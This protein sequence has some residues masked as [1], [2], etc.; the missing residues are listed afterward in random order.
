VIA[1][2]QGGFLITKIKHVSE[3]VFDRLLK[4]HDVEISPAQ[5]RILFVLWQEDRVPIQTLVE[6]SSLSKSTLT[7]MLDRLEKMG[8]VQRVRSAAD[9]RVILIARTDKDRAL[10]DTYRRVSEEMTE[11]YYA[12][13][14]EEE[15]LAFESTL[16]RIL[17]N[18]VRADSSL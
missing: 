17:D 6:R 4:R 13:L 9:R 12:G 14:S 1:R 5:G 15:I 11:L 8:Y 2:Y 16:Q 10:E 3:R 7:S 18:M